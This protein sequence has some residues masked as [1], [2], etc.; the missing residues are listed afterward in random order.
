MATQSIAGYNGK[1]Y[2]SID[3]GTT[4]VEIGELQDVKLKIDTKLLNATSHAAAR[5][6]LVPADRNWY[7]DYVIA[8]ATVEALE[9]LRLK[10]PKL[11]KGLANL[12]IR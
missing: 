5:W 1:C 6:H 11:G 2:V 4:Y 12:R 7:R 10:W 3:G 9:G 8:A